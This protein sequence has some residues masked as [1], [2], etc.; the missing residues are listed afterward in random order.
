MSGSPALLWVGRLDANKDPLCVIDACAAVLTGFPDATLTMV[1]GQDD[2]LPRVRVRIA[3]HAGL[4]GR[5]RLVGRVPYERLALFYSAADVFVLGSHH[6][7]SG[8]AVIEACACGVPL[9]ITAIPPFRAHRPTKTSSWTS[10][11]TRSK[12][13]SCHRGTPSGLVY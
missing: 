6:E 11:L 2:L 3:E 9:A 12:S 13:P 5:V 10:R 1:F 7:G 8:Y 4:A